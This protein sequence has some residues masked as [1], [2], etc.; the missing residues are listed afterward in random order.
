MICSKCYNEKEF[1]VKEEKEII[2][3][4]GEPIEITSKV[5][6]CKNCGEQIWNPEL[7]DENLDTA[8][9]CYR[10]KHNL[11]MPEEIKEIR[12]RLELSQK[13][14]SKLL[15]I[16][17]KTIT[18]YE[19]GAIQDQAHNNLILLADSLENF[20]LL[21]AKQKYKFDQK[22]QLK[23]E[24]FLKKH[25]LRLIENKYIKPINFDHKYCTGELKND[26]STQYQFNSAV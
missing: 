22:E 17:E 14:F 8:Y 24:E 23:I 25:K 13:S 19:N 2:K 4:K 12:K 9:R 5:T 18:R 10:K 6:Y 11:L 15:G 16:G 20:N 21:Y 3:V 7:D 1:I 26:R